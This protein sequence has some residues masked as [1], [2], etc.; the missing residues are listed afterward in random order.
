M[1]SGISFCETQTLMTD[2]CSSFCTPR[3]GLFR[4]VGISG[5]HC[6]PKFRGTVGACGFEEGQAETGG[7][8]SLLLP[9]YIYFGKWV[10][11]INDNILLQLFTTRKQVYTTHDLTFI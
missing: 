5:L 10:S 8:S 4:Q 2:L 1:E 6:P 3:F 11:F 7:T 9:Q